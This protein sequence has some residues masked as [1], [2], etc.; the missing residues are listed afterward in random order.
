MNLDITN[1]ACFGF[2]TPANAC[3]TKI[4][5]VAS[6]WNEA[7]KKMVEKSL[8]GDIET[9]YYRLASVNLKDLDS[10]TE[11]YVSFI[12][13][14][15]LWDAEIVGSKEAEVSPEEKDE[16]FKSE[17]F[18]K[19]LNKAVSFIEGARGLYQEVV[20]QHLE[21]GDLLQV[22]E[23]KAEAV[24]HFVNDANLMRAFKQAKYV[25]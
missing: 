15:K 6:A 22:D 13:G 1:V 12:N 21:A 7:S 23:T 14:K 24:E 2:T 17:E 10:D 25:K 11:Y 19:F 5:A 18:K 16:L 3:W 9:S 20:K 4:G 8:A